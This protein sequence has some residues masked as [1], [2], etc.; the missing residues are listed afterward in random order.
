[1]S[2]VVGDREAGLGDARTRCT[3]VCLSGVD[4]VEMRVVEAL[5]A[6]EERGEGGGGG[7]GRACPGGGALSPQS[8]L[9]ADR[10]LLCQKGRCLLAFLDLRLHRTF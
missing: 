8:L 6:R 9:S 10:Q 4:A 7:G 5:S 2:G 3:G 1:M